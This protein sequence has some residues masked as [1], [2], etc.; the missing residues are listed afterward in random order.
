MGSNPQRGS[1]PA[2]M[3]L[4]RLSPNDVEMSNR[5]GFSAGSAG[6]GQASSE[7]Q[8]EA[9]EW[10][11]ELHRERFGHLIS[12]TISRLLANNFHKIG[13]G[14]LAPSES[15]AT[16]TLAGHGV[17]ENHGLGP[18]PQASRSDLEVI[19]PSSE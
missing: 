10:V 5:L 14:K 6:S 13:S 16:R 8:M 15:A 4:R 11:R 7:G 1:W 2:A 9:T 19:T 17:P 3:K 18:E 12:G